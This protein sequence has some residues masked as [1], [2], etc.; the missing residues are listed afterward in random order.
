MMN[1][2]IKLRSLPLRQTLARVWLVNKQYSS[3][4]GDDHVDA[5]IKTIQRNEESYYGNVK[6]SFDALQSNRCNESIDEKRARLMYQSRKRGTSENGL[7][8]GNFSAEFLPGMSEEELND[9]DNIIN[10]LH[11][12]W[13]LYYWLT[14]AKPIPDEIKESKILQRMKVYCANEN[15]QSR[16]V[17]PDLPHM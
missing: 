2:L 16:L 10:N 9:Y 8:L 5:T 13:E 15:K 14:N 11:N 17:L 1:G 4:S 7:L 12:E 6:K 3:K